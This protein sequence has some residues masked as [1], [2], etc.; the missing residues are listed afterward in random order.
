[1]RFESKRA[2]PVVNLEDYCD[3]VSQPPPEWASDSCRS[4]QGIFLSA[5]R[6]RDHSYV[7]GSRQY[8][9]WSADAM[10][11]HDIQATLFADCAQKMRAKYRKAQAYPVVERSS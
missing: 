1:M 9:A 4:G 11:S 6:L 8:A 5:C 2:A 7:V 10:G 3:L